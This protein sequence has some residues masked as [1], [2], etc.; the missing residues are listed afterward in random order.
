MGSAQ[1]IS[2]P[3][4]F[5]HDGWG[6]QAVVHGD[7]CTACGNDPGLDTCETEMANAFEV[8]M[9]GKLGHDENDG[10]TMRVL[11]RMLR[12]TLKGLLCETNPAT[13]NSL[14]KRWASTSAATNLSRRA[15]SLRHLMAPSLAN[16]VATSPM[17][18]VASRSHPPKPDSTTT[19]PHTTLH[20][21]LRLIESTQT[22]SYPLARLT[23]VENQDIV[24]IKPKHDIFTGLGSAAMEV[25]RAEFRSC[26]ATQTHIRTTVCDMLCMKALH[27]KNTMLT[28]STLPRTRRTATQTWLAGSEDRRAAPACW[29][30]P[31]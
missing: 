27:A 18:F 12:V 22:S 24:H 4:V 5:K 25:R 23:C 26:L 2:S 29:R 17:L 15:R 13:L 31:Q 19:S 6:V 21:S 11:N 20:P 7:D 14:H 1:E 16:R 28:E 10:E 9:K 30:R 8:N 3:C